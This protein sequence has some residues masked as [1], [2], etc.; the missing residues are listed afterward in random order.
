MTKIRLKE[1]K[2]VYLKVAHAYQAGRGCRLTA[3]DAEALIVFDVAFKICAEKAQ[4]VA[5]G[6]SG[7]EADEIMD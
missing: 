1:E 3:E 4:L 5:D 2:S 7:Q 6:Y